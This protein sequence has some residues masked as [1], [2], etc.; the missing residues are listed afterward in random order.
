VG[1]RAA[2][3]ARELGAHA[4]HAGGEIDV[5]PDEAERLGDAQ[6]GEEDGREHQPVALR[7][8]GE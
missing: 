7:A 1:G 6:A 8:G 3:G 2:V 5:V 4:D